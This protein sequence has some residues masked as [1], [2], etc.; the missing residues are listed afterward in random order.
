MNSLQIQ[1]LGT[2][3]VRRGDQPVQWRAASARGLFFYLMTYPA[4]RSRTQIIGALWNADPDA[5]LSN[6]FRVAVHRTRAALGA[7]DTLLE[8]HNRYRLS[9]EVL[10]ASDVQAFQNGLDAVRRDSLPLSRLARLQDLIHRFAGDYLPLESADWA[11]QA[12]EEHRATYVQAQTELS[13]LHCGA[14]ACARS[15]ESLAV[16]LKSDPYMGENH[17]QRL[18][19]CV[20]CSPNR[21]MAWAGTCFA[22][23]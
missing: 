21:R 8:D 23:A 16:A 2:A 20:I 10:A 13:G 4:G 12:R 18:M 15:V 14:G 17:H 9:P 11:F 6:R 7:K 3:E 1:M 5:Q 19:T 22:G